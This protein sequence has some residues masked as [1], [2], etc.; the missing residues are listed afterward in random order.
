MALDWLLRGH[1]D[2]VRTVAH[3]NSSLAG[4]CARGR[5][6]VDTDRSRVMDGFCRI[7]RSVPCWCHGPA[8]VIYPG[9]SNRVQFTGV[10]ARQAAIDYARRQNGLPLKGE[11]VE[12]I[13]G[14][15]RIGD[16]L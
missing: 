1:S 10:D 3:V 8:N 14:P 7:C 16:G 9:T 4:V 13:W 6:A 5:V 11:V 12:T 2:A 15:V